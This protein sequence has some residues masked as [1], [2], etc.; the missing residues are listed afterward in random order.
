MSFCTNESQLFALRVVVVV[1]R[2]S[3]DVVKSM[4]D[5]LMEGLRSLGGH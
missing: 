2:C 5:I 3:E 1:A 4:A